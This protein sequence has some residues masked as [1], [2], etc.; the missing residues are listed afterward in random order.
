MYPQL[1]QQLVDEEQLP[2]SYAVDANQWFVPLIKSLRDQLRERGSK[3]FLLGINGA[4]GTGKTTL[5]KL[6]KLCMERGGY[7][8]VVL[9]IDDFYLG[10]SARQALAAEVH[11]L[12][13]TRGVPG[14]HDIDRLRSVLATLRDA[15]P[16]LPLLLPRFDKATDDLM[17]EHQGYRVTS[18]PQLIL[19]EGWFIG[20]SAEQDSALD[21]PINHLEE[22][23]DPQGVW[24]R[25]VNRRLARDYVP[26]FEQLDELLMLKAPSF[27]MVYEWRGLQ[28]RKLRESRGENSSGVMTEQQLR[29]FI[30][31]YERL[32]RHCLASLAEHADIV[33]GLDQEHRIVSR[34]R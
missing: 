27:E 29:R 16:A 34:L 17:P 14:T 21:A 28:E 18:Q 26:I 9:S 20:V 24:R 19:L 13:A 3:P 2:G 25:F 5:C 1:I 11:P 10:K 30:E 31:H 33:Y 12:L 15:K 8:V 23:E 4:Q 22:T 6:I 7:T 32:T